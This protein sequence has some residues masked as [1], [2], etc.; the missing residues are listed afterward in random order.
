LV[1][2]FTLLCVVIDVWKEYKEDAGGTH[3]T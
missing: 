3:R 2:S 1:G